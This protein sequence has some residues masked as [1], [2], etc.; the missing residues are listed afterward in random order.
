MINHLIANY[1]ARAEARLVHPVLRVRTISPQALGF[2][3]LLSSLAGAGIAA[4]SFII[5][6]PG[7]S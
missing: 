4:L 3:V 1:L 7:L 5:Y 2:T 6:I